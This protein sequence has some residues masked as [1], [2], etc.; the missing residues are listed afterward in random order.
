MQE[1]ANH[2]AAR[3]RAADV[4]WRTPRPIITT[5]YER[6]LQVVLGH[7]IVWVLRYTV[8]GASNALNWYLNLLANAAGACIHEY[9]EEQHWGCNPDGGA[10]LVSH[11]KRLSRELF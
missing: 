8:V 11:C 3:A 10:Y 6:Y 1:M 2:E 9:D 4:C 5:P 7:C